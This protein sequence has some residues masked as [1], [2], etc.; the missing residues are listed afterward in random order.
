MLKGTSKV[1]SNLLFE[2][3]GL[4]LN[5]D[6]VVCCQFNIQSDI[7]N[8]K[9]RDCTA[10]LYNLLFCLTVSMVKK[11]LLINSLNLCFYAQC[12]QSSHHVEPDFV[13]FV[14]SS[15]DL[16][17]AFWSFGKYLFPSPSKPSFLKPPCRADVPTLTIREVL[18]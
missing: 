18:H 1:Q 15:Q 10:P 2:Q 9:D 13:P 4:V 14:S 3:A 12:L 6:Q 8:S 16:E 5:L 17:A 11:V 7:E